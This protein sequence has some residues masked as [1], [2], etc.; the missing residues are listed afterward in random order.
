MSETHI[1]L[2]V[3]HLNPQIL[4]NTQEWHKR[5]HLYARK[6]QPR[7]SGDRRETSPRSISL[8]ENI[9]PTVDSPL[10]PALSPDK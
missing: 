2:Y 4:L 6:E 1:W 7:L 3:E 9:C 5:T 8:K 10:H